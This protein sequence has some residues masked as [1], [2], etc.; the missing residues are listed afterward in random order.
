MV[1]YPNFLA[2]L[3]SLASSGSIFQFLNLLR[4]ISLPI[5]ASWVSVSLIT[6]RIF[7]FALLVQTSFNQSALGF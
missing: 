3:E 1:L 4:R 2:S 7:C 6:C 5:F